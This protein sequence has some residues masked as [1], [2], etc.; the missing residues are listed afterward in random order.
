MLDNK[1][2]NLMNEIDWLLSDEITN[3]ELQNHIDDRRHP[4]ER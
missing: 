3:E 1:H 2:K 4:D